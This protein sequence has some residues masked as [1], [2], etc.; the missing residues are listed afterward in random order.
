MPDFLT[1]YYENS[2][3]PFSN[4]SLLPL[5]QAEQILEE[6]R[7]TG[8]RFASQRSSDYLKKR[9]ELENKI[10]K[11]FE[12]KGGQPK[13]RRPHY[14]ILGTCPWL[15]GWYVDGQEVQ[16]KLALISE[17]CV[18]FTYGDSFPAINY[19]DGKP[20]RGQVYT[21]SELEE[22]IR[23]YGLPQEWNSD[24]SGGPERYIE[25]QIW[26]DAPLQKYLSVSCTV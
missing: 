10:R 7:R 6:I 3:G 20:Y 13:L 2:A 1:H 16:I 4:L 26:D 25:A 21:V 11:L 24:G 14:M 8:N 23:R 18:S 5:E 22:V 19:Q 15:K 12:E 9:L 17:S